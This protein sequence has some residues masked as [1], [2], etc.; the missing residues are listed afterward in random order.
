MPEGYL[1]PLFEQNTLSHCLPLAGYGTM[2]PMKLYHTFIRSLVADLLLIKKDYGKYTLCYFALVVSAQVVPLATAAIPALPRFLSFLTVL[3]SLLQS[4]NHILF[5]R[6]YTN[7][8]IGNGAFNPIPAVIAHTYLIYFVQIM[9]FLFPAAVIMGGVTLI[10]PK[11]V[12]GGAPIMLVVKIGLLIL[13]AWW[14]MGLVFVPMILVYQKESMKG[15]LIVAESRAIFRK[16]YRMVI[17]FFLILYL[18]SVYTA[19]QIVNAHA[20]VF[21]PVANTVRIIIVILSGYIS[22]LVYCKLVIEYQLQM[23]QRFLPGPK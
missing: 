5:Q 20:Q 6:A 17:P 4:V 18:S 23:A 13:M 14:I 11:T 1:R 2:A 3:L 19:Y 7:Q 10:I 21:P 9:L 12:G 8:K 16:Q 15:K 22:S